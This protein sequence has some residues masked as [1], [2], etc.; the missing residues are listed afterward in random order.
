MF[1]WGWAAICGIRSP[2]VILSHANLP[3]WIRVPNNVGRDK[4]EPLMDPDCVSWPRTVAIKL[5]PSPCSHLKSTLGLGSVM[6]DLPR[7]LKRSERLPCPGDFWFGQL[8]LLGTTAFMGCVDF[9]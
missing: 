6:L 2:W 3:K 8:Q 4:D 7:R 1:F 5:A 9:G